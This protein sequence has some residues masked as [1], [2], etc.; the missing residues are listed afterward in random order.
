MTGMTI[1]SEHI[2]S[3]VTWLEG[4]FTLSPD[5][6]INR[7][8]AIGIMAEYDLVVS[9]N[10]PHQ[11]PGLDE[12]TCFTL[13]LPKPWGMDRF[14]TASDYLTLVLTHPKFSGFVWVEVRTQ[15]EPVKKNEPPCEWTRLMESCIGPT[16]QQCENKNEK[17][18]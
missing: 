12:G 15:H 3:L 5:I 14:H 18:I 17:P 9:V 7:Y 8:E 11:R 2:K 6:E 13:P 4:S 10:P 1:P 16:L